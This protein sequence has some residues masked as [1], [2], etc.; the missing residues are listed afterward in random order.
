VQVG[1]RAK[2]DRNPKFSPRTAWGKWRVNVFFEILTYCFDVLCFWAVWKVLD[3]VFSRII[4]RFR[5]DAQTPN[6]PVIINF[7]Q[8]L[9]DREPEPRIYKITDYLEKKEEMSDRQGAPNASSME[10]AD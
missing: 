1:T 9:R 4:R 7:E 8:Y 5:M 3:T 10:A 6:E 2:D